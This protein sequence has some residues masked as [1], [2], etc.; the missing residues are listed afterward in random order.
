MTQEKTT[1][2][3]MVE[4]TLDRDMAVAGVERK[5]GNKV[6]VSKAAADWIAKLPKPVPEK[7]E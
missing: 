3:D 5:K 4:I 6:K 7:P 2:P 1:K